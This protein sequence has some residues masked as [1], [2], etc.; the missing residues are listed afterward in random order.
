MDW[1]RSSSQPGYIWPVAGEGQLHSPY[2][3]TLSP[4]QSSAQL[5]CYQSVRYSHHSSCHSPSLCLL[6]PLFCLW[7]QKIRSVAGPFRG[8][9]A[10][11]SATGESG[12]SHMEVMGNLQEQGAAAG[13]TWRGWRLLGQGRQGRRAVPGE[14]WGVWKRMELLA[15]RR[16]SL[17]LCRRRGDLLQ[18]FVKQIQPPAPEAAQLYSAIS[19]NSKKQVKMI[20]NEQLCQK[21]YADQY[22]GLIQHSA[23]TQMVLYLPDI[24]LSEL[25]LFHGL[26][27]KD[28]AM[29]IYTKHQFILPAEKCSSLHNLHMLL[30]KDLFFIQILAGE[31]P[32]S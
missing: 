7:I 12:C 31:F 11:W 10:A 19:H 4:L 15:G 25:F 23:F 8:N 14:V 22:D 30:S 1:R 16:D 21:H 6:L 27:M 5:L 28:L 2:V 20:S 9:G 29:I 18:G 17:Q 32:C 13:G 24:I 3:K 26:L